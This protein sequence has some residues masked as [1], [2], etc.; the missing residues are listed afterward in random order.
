M[1]LATGSLT[2]AKTI[3]DHPRLLLDG[4]GRGVPACRDDVWL[5]A[6]QL[7]RERL[8]PIV[9]I[10]GPTKVHPHVAAIDP[11]Q[12]RKRLQERRDVRQTRGRAAPQE[13]A[14][15]PHAVALLRPRRERPR[16]RAA[17]ERDEIA[18]S[19]HSISSL[20][21]RERDSFAI[22]SLQSAKRKSMESYQGLA[23]GEYIRFQPKSTIATAT[24]RPCIELRLPH[25]T[26]RPTPRL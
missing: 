5:Q 6:H 24:R 13:H 25:V 15:A 10:A 4:S 19:N 2:L 8:K 14:D 7:L 20:A 17:E 23:G 1:P 21:L 22:H 26:P 11:T 12:A 16:R 18:A 9:V 3:G